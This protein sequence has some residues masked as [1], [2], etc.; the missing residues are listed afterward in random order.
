M[1]SHIMD[2]TNVVLLFVA[3]A[4]AGYMVVLFYLNSKVKT[5]QARLPEEYAS[6]RTPV[7]LVGL[8]VGGIF[9]LMLLLFSVGVIF[10]RNEF[11]PR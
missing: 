5:D 7:S 11:L 9:L 1:N 10:F 2:I 6:L 3:L 4:L 8:A